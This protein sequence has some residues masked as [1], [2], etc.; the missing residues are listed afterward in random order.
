[1]LRRTKGLLPLVTVVALAAVLAVPASAQMNRFAKSLGSMAHEGNWPEAVMCG[2]SFT[3]DVTMTNPHNAVW[4]ETD[5]HKLGPL[6]GEDEVFRPDGHRFK[7]PDGTTVPYGGKHTFSLELTAPEEAGTYET[8][9][10]MMTKGEPYGAP[11]KRSIR[12]YCDHAELGRALFPSD[13]PCG[14]TFKAEV[15]MINSGKS[16]WTEARF[17][18]LGPVMGVEEPFR[19]D[20]HKFKMPD[21][22]EVAP[23]DKY[24]FEVELTA[25]EKYGTYETKWVMMQGGNPFGEEVSR[26]IDVKCKR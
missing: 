21:G 4:T 19:S 24:V 26:T 22:T 23:G 2:D 3:V 20:G 9:W 25:P 6:M 8:E 13:V 7:M 5:F 18:K 15:R 10:S 1:M 11:I 16:D 14:Q 17:Y 12:V